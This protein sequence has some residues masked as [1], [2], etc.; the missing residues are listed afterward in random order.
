MTD[1]AVG[2]VQKGLRGAVVLGQD[3]LAGFRVVFHKIENVADRGPAEFIDALIIVPDHDDVL[4]V[5]SQ[6]AN[7]LELC[8]VC[9]LEFVHQDE[10]EPFLVSL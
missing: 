10:T 9:I 3:D 6:K 5:L 1:Q 2:G 7:Q 8:V 4:M